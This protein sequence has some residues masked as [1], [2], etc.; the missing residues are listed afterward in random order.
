MPMCN[1]LVTLVCLSALPCLPLPLAERASL[2]NMLHQTLAFDLSQSP[3]TLHSP[4]GRSLP[5]HLTW[6][7]CWAVGPS[8]VLEKSDV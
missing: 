4:Q 7:A 6:P 5:H 1:H 2:S 8:N 3:L